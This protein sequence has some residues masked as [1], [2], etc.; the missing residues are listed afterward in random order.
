MFLNLGPQHP[1][2]HG[3]LRV[4]LQLDGEEIRDAVL[5]IGYHHRGAEK[6]AER[7]TWHT[8]IPYT[9]RIDYFGGVMNNLAY[10]L[11][12]EKLAGI[13]V[14][15]R[16]KVIRVMM[17]ELFRIQ[18][19]LVWYGTYAQDVGYLSPVF[20]TFTDRERV[21]GIIEA[22]CGGRMHPAWFRIGG[23]A[24]D[25]PRGWDRLVTDF[26]KYLPPRLAEYDK[27]VMRNSIFRGRTRGVGAY[28]LVF[29]PPFIR[30]MP[31][32]Y[33]RE[34]GETRLARRAESFEDLVAGNA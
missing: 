14:P 29:K 13:E 2:T 34:G 3:L 31:P 18:S 27:L 17:A 25:L 6:M 11:A 10:V 19:H 4:I 33:V 8:Y 15:D 9:D 7:Q 20:Y 23:L 22:V 16:V 32:V 28:T 21:F 12:V 5:D 24:Q 30:P 26:L 1:G